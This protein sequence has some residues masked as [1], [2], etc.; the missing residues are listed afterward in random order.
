[1]KN[2]DCP[3]NRRSV[4]SPAGPWPTGVPFETSSLIEW[5]ELFELTL[6]S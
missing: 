4:P 1:M 5:P 3:D 6:R 2:D